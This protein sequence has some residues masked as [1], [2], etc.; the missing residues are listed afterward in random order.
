[1]ATILHV[2]VHDTH[3]KTAQKLDLQRQNIDLLSDIPNTTNSGHSPR[4]I[5]EPVLTM[6]HG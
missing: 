6:S 4:D 3:C 1:M 5:K 2:Y